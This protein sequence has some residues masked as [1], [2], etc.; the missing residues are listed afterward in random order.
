MPL[1]TRASSP[2]LYTLGSSK[3]SHRVSVFKYSSMDDRR[4]WYQVGD[5]DRHLGSFT[6][7]AGVK[8]VCLQAC[9]A[10]QR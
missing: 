1:D 10:A 3:L 6:P 4:D 2:D 9:R 5:F 8:C 7:S